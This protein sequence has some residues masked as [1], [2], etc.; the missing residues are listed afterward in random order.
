MKPYDLARLRA[1]ALETRYRT[2][3]GYGGLFVPGGELLELLDYVEKSAFEHVEA[4]LRRVGAERVC[5]RPGFVTAF[6][7]RIDVSATSLQSAISALG[8]ERTP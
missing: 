4:E 8:K 2:V 3:D 1:A 5:M 6:D 7:R